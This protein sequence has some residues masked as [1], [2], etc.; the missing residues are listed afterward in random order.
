MLA[1]QLVAGHGFTLPA[2]WWP[3]TRAGQPTA[4]WSYLYT[5]YLAGVYWL[6]GGHALAARLLQGIV[7]GALQPWLAFRIA[8]RVFDRRA[9]LAAAAVTAVYAYFVYYSGALMTESFFI[10]AV[11]WSLDVATRLALPAEG[12]PFARWRRWLELG[13]ALGIGILLRQLLLF[14]VPFLLLW[15]Y[16]GTDACGVRGERRSVR[17]MVVTLVAIAVTIAP[18][19]IRNYRAFDRFVLLNTNAG[20]VLFWGNHPIHD[21]RFMPI[22]PA[23][24]P[25]YSE[26]I[27]DELRGLDEAALDRALLWR[28]IRF[29]VDDPGRYLAL[30]LSR[31]EEYFKFWWSAESGT[32]S[33]LARVLSFGLFLPFMAL[34]IALSASRAGPAV[35]LLLGFVVLYTS[36]HL[37]TWTLV[38]YRLPVDAV[39]VLFA[40]VGVVWAFDRLSARLK[41]Q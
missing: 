21:R 33:N 36:L 9:G 1:R 8:R 19:T 4:H 16:A 41:L 2:D 14:L 28:G 25:T 20:Y 37:M 6:T 34:G 24:G 39:L 15:L 29:I 27:P 40:G 31:A 3:A 12:Q 38:R 13:L 26:L 17:G 22:L 18:W 10:L 5:S 7:V 23:G 32:I 11:L 30:S 35:T